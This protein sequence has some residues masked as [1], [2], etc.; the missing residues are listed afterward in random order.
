MDLIHNPPPP[1][2]LLKIGWTWSHFLF[3]TLFHCHQKYGPSFSK[4]D[5]RRWMDD[6][7]RYLFPSIHASFN[8]TLSDFCRK[9]AL[10][11]YTPSLWTSV[12]V[13]NSLPMHALITVVGLEAFCPKKYA[14]SERET[15]RVK[16]M[17]MQ[18]CRQRIYHSRCT[19][20]NELCVWCA[21]VRHV[22]RTHTYR[23]YVSLYGTCCIDF[24]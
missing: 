22:R 9:T 18:S 3:V 7:R 10:S 24:Y 11:I 15:W 16:T 21:G 5:K 8:W 1:P 6:W 14:K 17:T 20:Q 19:V 13:Y 4:N 23:S 2:R 12:V